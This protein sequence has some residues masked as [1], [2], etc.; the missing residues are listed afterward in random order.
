M[1]RMT[2]GD[3]IKWLC[4]CLILSRLSLIVI[5]YL[6]PTYEEAPPQVLSYLPKADLSFSSQDALPCLQE[7]GLIMP[8]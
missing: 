6:L 3:K 4:T 8:S 1:T 5:Y 7:R 2:P